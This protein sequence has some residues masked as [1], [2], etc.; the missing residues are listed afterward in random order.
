MVSASQQVAL[1]QPVAE[2][3]TALPLF[4]G[5]APLQVVKVSHVFAAWR[6]M[7]KSADLSRASSVWETWY[8]ALGRYR[9]SMCIK[10]VLKRSPHNCP[11]GGFAEVKLL[12]V[13]SKTRS[14]AS[15]L[16]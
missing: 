13:V 7:G 10:H 4:T 9:D 12:P 15:T 16:I 2:H 6:H 11:Y 5:V 8:K 14:L 1:S 3:V